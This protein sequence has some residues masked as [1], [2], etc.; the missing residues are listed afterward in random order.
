M[1]NKKSLLT[2]ESFLTSS[3]CTSQLTL[4]QMLGAM[5]SFISCPEY[6]EEA[7]L[8]ELIVGNTDEG[9]IKV[10]EPGPVHHA[11]IDIFNQID[12][13]LEHEHF[14]LTRHYQITDCMNQPPEQLSQWCEGYLK[15]S[16]LTQ[17]IWQEDF[18]LLDTIPDFK[19]GHNLILECDACLNLI[20]MFADWDRA[21]KVNNNPELLKSQVLNI[22]SSIDQGVALFY[23]L[24]ISFNEIKID[25]ID[26]DL[27]NIENL[28]EIDMLTK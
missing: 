6:I 17:N 10:I 9:F 21:L 20:S 8:E 12:S 16:Q 13:A 28:K 27:L 18:N 23:Q 5:T 15:G 24:G 19:K 11:W 4:N 2:M 22:C 14:S 26:F 7:N 25:V 1:L 3:L